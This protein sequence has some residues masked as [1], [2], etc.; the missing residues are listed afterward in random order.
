MND[1][2]KD[3]S[4]ESHSQSNPIWKLLLSGKSV[5]RKHMNKTVGNESENKI[6]ISLDLKEMIRLKS[7]SSGK[8]K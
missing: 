7:R 8:Y 1:F 2:I 6:N 3:I 4:I 5:E